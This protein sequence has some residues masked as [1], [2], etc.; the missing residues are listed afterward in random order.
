[1][2]NSIVID[3]FLLEKAFDD[4]NLPYPKDRIYSFYEKEQNIYCAIEYA[5]ENMNAI[6]KMLPQGKVALNSEE[7]GR[8][9]AKLE[10]WIEYIAITTVGLGDVLATILKEVFELNVNRPYFHSMEEKLKQAKKEKK[11]SP[12]IE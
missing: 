11:I 9:F 6:I 12:K 10:I 1:M 3:T 5:K 8:L 4:L 7:C 2:K